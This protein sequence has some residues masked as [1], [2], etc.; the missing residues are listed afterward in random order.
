MVRQWQPQPVC[1]QAALGTPASPVGW[2][3]GFRYPAAAAGRS[4]L[5]RASPD[6]QASFVTSCPPPSLS[7]AIRRPMTQVAQCDAS[8]GPPRQGAITSPKPPGT[9]SNDRG[10]GLLIED[11]GR[12]A[13][14]GLGTD[15]MLG[16]G[17]KS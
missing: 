13:A 5:T 1:R 17:F 14:L 16:G 4:S 11:G 3:V 12:P 15:R 9:R 6:R 8:G 10:L 7:S 2:Y